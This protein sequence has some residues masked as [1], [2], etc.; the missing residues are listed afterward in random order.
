ME[1]RAAGP[2]GHQTFVPVELRAVR[3]A[4]RLRLV[5]GPKLIG[6]VDCLEGMSWVANLPGRI[7]DCGRLD[8]KSRLQADRAVVS[9]EQRRELLLSAGH[10]TEVGG[11]RMLECNP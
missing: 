9:A 3:F 6:F 10:A 11:R 4:G 7:V 2:I 8:A 1:T 5:S